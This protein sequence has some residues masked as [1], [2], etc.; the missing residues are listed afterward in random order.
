MTPI[1]NTPDIAKIITGSK[2]VTAMNGD[3]EAANVTVTRYT[4][5][6]SESLNW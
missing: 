5:N 2:S 6:P 3:L 1:N 4:Y